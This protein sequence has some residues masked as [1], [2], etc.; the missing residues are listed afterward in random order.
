[1]LVKNPVSA[2]GPPPP[3]S[4]ILDPPLN[5]RLATTEGMSKKDRH[6]LYPTPPPPKRGK[7]RKGYFTI[8]LVV[9]LSLS[10]TGVNTPLKLELPNL[11]SLDQ[12]YH[13]G[14]GSVLFLALWDLAPQ[15]WH[16]DGNL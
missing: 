2:P 13:A 12:F 3:L 11:K 5:G 6:P 15:P 16:K 4:K 1:M 7:T 9:V 8:C 10:C 14:K